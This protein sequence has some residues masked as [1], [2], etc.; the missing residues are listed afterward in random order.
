[1]W[2]IQGMKD[3]ASKGDSTVKSA[4]SSASLKQT[5]FLSGAVNFK[6]LTNEKLKQA[7]E[8]LRTIMYLSCWGP[9]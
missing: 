6:A 5:R 3:Q 9:N 7:E 8:S 4:F 1:M 2:V